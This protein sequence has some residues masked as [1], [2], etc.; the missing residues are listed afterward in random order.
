MQYFSTLPKVVYYDKNKVSKVF[1]NLMARA[2][3]KPSLLDNPLVFYTYDIQDDDTPEIVAYKYYG[4]IYRY[5]IVLYS[6]EMMDPQWDW[7][8]SRN[9]FEEY[10]TNK[11]QDI[12]PYSSAHHYEKTITSYDQNTLTTTTNT[13]II[14]EH[15]Y[16]LLNETTNTYLLATGTVNVSVTKKAVSY[17]EYELKKNESKRNIKILNKNFVNQLETELKKL[18]K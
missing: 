17:Y 7:P 2:N 8:L 3:I 16:D 13:I 5:W 9:Q 15:T 6:N 1:T 18:M 4:D 10:I 12:D 11:Y 14:D